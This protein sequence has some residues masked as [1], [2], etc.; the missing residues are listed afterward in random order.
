MNDF[1]EIMDQVLYKLRDKYPQYRIEVLKMKDN[2]SY[3]EVNDK[4]VFK[5]DPSFIR[6]EVEFLEEHDRYVEFLVSYFDEPLKIYHKKHTRQLLRGMGSKGISIQKIIEA[7]NATK[8]C[9]A[10]A[11]YLNVSYNTFKKYASQYFK[12]D[13]KSYFEAQLNERGIGISKGTGPN[14][15]KYT[16]ADIQEGRV[17][18]DYPAFRYKYRLIRTGILPERCDNCGFEEQRLSD[19]KVPLQLDFVDGNPT[20]RHL[21]NIRLLCYNCYFLLVGN[22]F[23][24][25]KGDF[26]PAYDTANKEKNEQ[27][28]KGIFKNND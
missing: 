6:K 25:K 24:R 26:T 21:E 16:M 15:G 18:D 13:G 7:C 17:P 9:N 4:R 11:N 19:G 1:N 27:S 23:W 14:V 28:Q 12:E 22:I 5:F 2:K 20:N 3:L 10:A 8:S